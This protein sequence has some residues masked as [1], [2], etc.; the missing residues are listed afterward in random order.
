MSCFSF[1]LTIVYATA[2]VGFVI[3]VTIQEAMNRKGKKSAG[4]A[5]AAWQNRLS[6]QWS[7]RDGIGYDRV[8]M[9]DP[10]LAGE[11]D[12]SATPIGNVN[13]ALSSRSTPGN[14]SSGTNSLVG[15]TS[16]S[17]IYD[18]E[19][20]RGRRPPSG[21]SGITSNSPDTSRH[22]LSRGASLLD[23]SSDPTENPFLQPRTYP[24]NTFLSTAFYKLGL[25]C[26]RR[27]YLTL[28][29]GFAFC[30]VVNLGWGRFEVEKDPVKL[31]VAKGS[32]S[33]R[34]KNDFDEAFGPFYR[35][36]QVFVSVAPAA[37][38]TAAAEDE[39]IV[40]NRW[41]PVDEPVLTWERLQWWASVEAAIRDLKSSPSNYSLADV[42]FSPQTEPLP[43]LD[44]SACVVQSMMGYFG[45][46]LESVREDT[47]ASNLN[48][49]ATTPAACLP[50]SGMPMNPKLVLGGV[51]A[52]GKDEVDSSP[53]RADQ[54]RALVITYVVRNS[55]DPA[56]VARAEEWES[57]LQAFLIDL[58]SP[59]GAARQNLGLE[60]A[61]S[62]GVSLEEELNKSTNTDVPIVALSYIVMFFYV[63]INLGSSGAGLVKS[64][65]RG[66]LLLVHG[67]VNLAG[68]VP[69]PKSIGSQ[70][71]GRAR[72]G[73]VSLS[74]AG[75]T[76]GMGAYF[77][78]QLLVD[79]KFLLGPFLPWIL[80]KRFTDFRPP[81]A[82]LWGIVIVL[83][84]VSTSVA[85]FSAFGVKVTLII[86]EVIPFLV[87]AIGVDNV[88]ILSH[89]L[90]QQ[91]A[92]AYATASCHGPLFGADDGQE[93]DDVDSLP[94]AEERVARALARMGPS[95]LLS[96]SCETVA[97]A[98]G[99]LVGM[100]AVR[101][102]AIYAAGAVVINALLQVTIFVSA[103]AVDLR[104]VEVSS[105]S[106]E[107]LRFAC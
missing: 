22:R 57:T 48:D 36:E 13:G 68:L 46:S 74:L 56:V 32:E 58:A 69:V 11:F 43:P 45:D 35:T 92:R 106:F 4:G 94:S 16:T 21:S 77:R 99:A 107:L 41:E 50:G 17:Q 39:E 49:C 63:S 15:A 23:P 37:R 53:L 95:I 62:T 83:L 42:C 51:P 2:L 64:V 19:E 9:E 28:A 33:E 6:W 102:F 25:F 29:A 1:A 20:G 100:P 70:G 75:S 71:L 78:R 98:L 82:G 61:Y 72:A 96:A 40:A 18:G 86:A 31:W 85:L 67:V 14:A 104:R 101:N 8:P 81:W 27:P 105:S 97:F 84:S 79:S 38:K 47:W 54:A 30:G 76:S 87:L 65:G 91:N 103:M 26:A 93:E 3:V 60:L 88:F 34:A 44:A 7:S 52:R 80:A 89:E 5:F 24:L 55:L 10:L 90:D 12:D 66:L 73:F 59:S